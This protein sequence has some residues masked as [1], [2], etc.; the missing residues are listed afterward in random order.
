MGS[1]QPEENVYFFHV[2]EGKLPLQRLPMDGRGKAPVFR[3]IARAL[4]SC[5]GYGTP[6]TTGKQ[7]EETG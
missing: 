3:G 2:F 1:I 7:C 5:S 6:D 4:L